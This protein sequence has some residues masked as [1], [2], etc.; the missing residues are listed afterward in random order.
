[1]L[2]LRQGDAAGELPVYLAPLR[3]A[4]TLTESFSISQTGDRGYRHDTVIVSV[5][6]VSRHKSTL[7]ANRLKTGEPYYGTIFPENREK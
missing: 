4:A 1:M 3:K 7:S 5:D 2:W 6:M